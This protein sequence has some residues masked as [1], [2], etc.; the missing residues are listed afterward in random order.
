MAVLA[1]VVESCLQAEC[2]LFKLALLLV[3]HSHVVKQLQ[4]DVLVALAA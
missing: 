4:G 1:K 2:T 3:A